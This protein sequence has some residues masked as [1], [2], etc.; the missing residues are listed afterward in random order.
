[1]QN[2]LIALLVLL[3]VIVPAAAWAQ[4]YRWTDSAG[5]VHYADAP[6]PQG[7]KY[8]KVHV[9]SSAP[10]SVSKNGTMQASAKVTKT[11]N[12]QG[13]SGS[14]PVADTSS[15]RKSVCERLS[16]N[17]AL[18]KGNQALNTSGA[19]GKL[20]AISAKDR[21]TQLRREQSQ[22]HQYCKH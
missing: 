16:S 8:S 1:M 18:L 19:N 22:Y 13:A 17:I 21:K 3:T 10:T 4:V 14:S 9:K 2:K 11:G 15:N 20:H 5:T 7:V 12:G 6:P